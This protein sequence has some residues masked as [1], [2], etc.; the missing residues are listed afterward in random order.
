MGPF[1][2]LVILSIGVGDRYVTWW[3]AKMRM[4]FESMMLLIECIAD[5]GNGFSPVE[6]GDS[7]PPT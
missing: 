2:V 5:V 3:G 1:I 6:H 4:F 7:T